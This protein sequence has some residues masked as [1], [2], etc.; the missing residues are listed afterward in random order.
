MEREGLAGNLRIEKKVLR[1]VLDGLFKSKRE[2][3]WLEILELA[4]NF[5]SCYD[6][7]V[8]WR[9]SCYDIVR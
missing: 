7:V 2:K 8:F 1:V 3:D 9:K 6:T 4:E 5:C